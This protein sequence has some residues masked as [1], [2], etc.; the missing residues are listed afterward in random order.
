MSQNAHSSKRR[1]SIFMAFFILTLAIVQLTGNGCWHPALRPVRDPHAY[2]VQI[3]L[4]ESKMAGQIRYQ[5]LADSLKWG[6]SRILA[7][8]PEL[9]LTDQ[10]SRDEGDVIQVEMLE[11]WD[12]DNYVRV[13]V[14]Y[15]DPDWPEMPAIEMPLDVRLDCWGVVQQGG[16]RPG[17]R[18]IMQLAIRINRPG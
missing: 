18:Q 2:V 16:V 17:S 12:D 7:A 13:K 8:Y 9:K 1:W 3:L 15:Q 10:G 5:K 4:I 6:G 11:L 14:H